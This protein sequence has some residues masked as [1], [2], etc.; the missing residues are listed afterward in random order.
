MKRLHVNLSVADLERSITF[1]STLFAA[2]PTVRKPDYAKWM[3]EDPR[4][5]LSI[6]TRGTR[7][8]LDHLGVQAEDEAE[9]HGVWDRLK[10]AG[11]PVLEQ[12]ETTCCY[13][14]SVK[15]WVHDPEGIAWETCLTRGESPVYGGD[16]APASSDA[17]ACCVTPT[18]QPIVIGGLARRA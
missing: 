10:A 9:L 4:V 1:Y 13:A 16:E 5:N 7:T 17:S 11:E 14:R 3:I 8:G 12:G 18:S 2:P 6:T 15:T